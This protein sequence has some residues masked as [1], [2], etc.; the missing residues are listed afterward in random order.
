MSRTIKHI[1]YGVFYLCVFGALAFGIFRASQPA[2]R[3]DDGAQNGNE[4]GV[5][6]GGACVS[7]T[8]KNGVILQSSGASVYR[9]GARTTGETHATSS[10]QVGA[11]RA[12]LVA[13][14]INES[15]EYAVQSFSYQF[16]ARE[17][18]GAPILLGS[19]VRTIFAGERLTIVHTLPAGAPQALY[20][21]AFTVLGGSRVLQSSLP[22]P[23]VT[24]RPG[25]VT[26]VT[27]NV[28]TVRGVVGN[29]GFSEAHTVTVI[30]ILF[31]HAEKRLA[32]F[33]T[34][35]TNIQP[36]TER[37]FTVRVPEDAGIAGVIDPEATAVYVHAE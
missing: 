19:G 12:I 8:I 34:V 26:T 36:T 20:N 28:V 16:V 10:G 22:T 3:C 37:P 2:P 31:D 14:V 4:R 33:E 17:E 13:D 24:V 7:C 30:T 21:L 6:C 15:P 23:S 25:T 27:E 9:L 32:A 11:P 5:D 1:V 29:D 18:N 35:L